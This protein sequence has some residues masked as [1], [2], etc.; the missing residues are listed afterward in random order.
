MSFGYS[1]NSRQWRKGDVVIRLF[2]DDVDA[3]ADA[4]ADDDPAEDDS[5]TA[6]ATR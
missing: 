2:P 4:F 6:D 3:H 5:P 1:D